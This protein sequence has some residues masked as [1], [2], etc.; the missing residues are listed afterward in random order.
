MTT[1]KLHFAIRFLLTADPYKGVEIR[2]MC[3]HPGVAHSDEMHWMSLI[4]FSGMLEATPVHVN[5]VSREKIVAVACSPLYPL[6]VVSKV[7]D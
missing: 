1:P 4:S 6:K 7:D 2:K 5:A 3:H